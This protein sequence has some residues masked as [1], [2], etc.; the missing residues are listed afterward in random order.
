MMAGGGV[1]PEIW[2]GLECTVNRVGDVRSDQL[3]RS[4]HEFRLDDIDRFA[5]LGIRALRYPV[6]WERHRASALASGSNWGYADRALDRLLDR[7][8]RPIVGLVHHGCG[9]SGTGLLDPAFGP[10]LA[11]YAREVAERYPW[12]GDWTPVNEPLTTARFSALYGHWYPHACDE[13]S[14]AR[15]VVNQCR[16][17][18]LAMEAIREV[19]P[20]ARLVQTEDLG[21]TFST[22]RLREQA[23]FENCRRWLTFDLLT[24]VVQ[25]GHRMWGHLQWAGIPE[26]ELAWFAEHPCP[27]SIVGVNHYLTSER[28]LDERTERYPA[29]A[30]GGNGQR[31]YADIEAIRA[32]EGS[33]TGPAARLTEVWQRYALPIAVTEAHLGCTR[34]EQMRW[35]RDVWDAACAVRSE[36]VD[37]RA[38]T[39]WSLLG[40]FDWAS[41]LTRCDSGYE[42]GVFDVRAP[43]PR[44]TALAGM[45]RELAGKGHSTHP[46]LAGDGWWR[47]PRRLLYGDASRCGA[48]TPTHVEA[49]AR[50]VVVV[51][52]RGTLGSA[53]VRECA[54]RGL[55]HRAYGRDEC[56]ARV[57]ASVQRMLDRDRPWLVINAAGHVQADEAE[58]HPLPCHHANVTVAAVL[59]SEC[60]RRGIE[61]LTFSSDLVFDGT[62]EP[63]YTESTPVAPLSVYGRCKADAE[64]LVSDAMP[65]A[66]IVRA[67]A[68]FSP[69]DDGNFVARVL[70]EVS[71]GRVV[72]AA[73]DV[74]ISPTYVPDLVRAS[75]DLAIDGERGIWH[76]A[77]AGAVS[78]AELAR[79]AV[80]RAGVS[81]DFVE[82]AR[83]AALGWVARRPRWSVLTSERGWIMPSLDDALG[84]C[85]AA[86]EPVATSAGPLSPHHF[87]TLPEASLVPGA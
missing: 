65:E 67:S 26:R 52:A 23:E 63:P 38:V 58:R 14:F 12:V 16:A 78:W 13:H 77:N 8:V 1:A 76:L 55:D 36:G 71:A 42:S 87:P 28:Y 69:W 68:F 33:D 47:T 53:F 9:P 86:R 31:G 54:V 20:G 66:L 45:V 51:G 29:S 56:D 18:V 44:P 85:I 10:H 81:T 41:L 62:A 50:P 75:L 27:P 19:H 7:N 73:S 17:V 83:A 24:G 3:R 32:Y 15:A 64:R 60:A 39:V 80:A 4:G 74:V 43:T 82:P 21:K 37:V 35:L 11:E 48:G 40:S 22:P 61:L 25:D 2:G 30:Q 6:L 49:S 34:E 59:A 5:N 57:V 46:V 72:R 79:R 84:R 70:A